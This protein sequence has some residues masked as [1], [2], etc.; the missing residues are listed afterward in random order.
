MA[1]LIL[2]SQAL[3]LDVYQW[4][5]QPPK[6]KEHQFGQVARKAIPISIFEQE[7]FKRL[8]RKQALVFK[9]RQI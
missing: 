7:Q 6:V 8:T 4:E 5:L 3:N 1:C 2:L 9:R